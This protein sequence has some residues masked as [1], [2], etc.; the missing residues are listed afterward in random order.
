MPRLLRNLS[1]LILA[2]SACAA[3]AASPSHAFRVETLAEGLK[4]PWSVAKLPDGRY[5]VTEREGRLRII[6]NGRLL[7]E[8]VGGV[9][10]VWAN[11]QGGLL[12]VVLH[13]DHAASPPEISSSGF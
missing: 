6:A 13:P 4:N 5:L 2:A 3:G 7:P 12:D 10:A 8:P 1:A 9:P 11:G